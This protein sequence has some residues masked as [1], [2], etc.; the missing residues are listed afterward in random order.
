MTSQVITK[1]S[2]EAF[3]QE[4]LFPV[5]TIL[6]TDPQRCGG[7]GPVTIVMKDG[8]RKVIDYEGI[9]GRMML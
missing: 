9:E 8:S 3:T 2:A 1:E 4:E 7:Y 6:Y 5:E